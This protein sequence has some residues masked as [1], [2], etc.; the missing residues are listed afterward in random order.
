MHFENSSVTV[1]GNLEFYNNTAVDKGGEIALQQQ[2]CA[3]LVMMRRCLEDS[4][5]ALVAS[6]LRTYSRYTLNPA[7]L[8]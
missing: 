6:T 3:K 5:P 1:R 2:A 4:F 8:K 7:T